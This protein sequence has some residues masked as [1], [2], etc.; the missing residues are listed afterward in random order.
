MANTIANLG[1]GIG[2][3]TSITSNNKPISATNGKSDFQQLLKS[4]LQESAGLQNKAQQSIQNL[5]TGGDV[6]QAQVFTDLRKAD[7]AMRMLLQIRNKLL[8]A[9]N[10]IKQMQF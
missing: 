4:T 3:L 8:E 7:L 10:E 5:L 6:T 1:S 2:R 9:F